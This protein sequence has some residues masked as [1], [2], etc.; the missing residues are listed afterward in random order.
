MKL[1]TLTTLAALLA[2]VALSGSAFAQAGAPSK[3]SGEVEANRDAPVSLPDAKPLPTPQVD[4]EKASRA[5]D[6]AAGADSY[7]TV[8][9]SRDGS[10]TE[11][12]ASDSLRAIVESSTPPAP[13]EK[14]GQLTVGAD[15]R[16]QI[17]DSSTYPFTA[18]G[19]LF[20]QNQSDGWATC[21]AA[22]IG[23]KTVITAAH[24]VYDHWNGGWMKQLMFVPGATDAE[25]APFGV[26]DWDSVHILQGYISNYDGE[27]YDSVM[28][29]DL[30]VIN[31][32]EPAGDT[33]G[34]LGFQIDNHGN[35]NAGIL[36]YPADKPEGTMWFA[37]C[38]IT[39]KNYGGLLP[40]ETG[41][42]F[43]HACDTYS[44]SSGSSIWELDDQD[45]PYVNGV[46]VAEDQERNYA[47]EINEANFNWLSQYYQ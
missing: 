46:N 11:T 33:L 37:K 47:T 45:L 8:T 10:V 20:G 18:I 31:L 25:T 43:W 39:D 12:E 42:N 22:L 7:G 35:W 17:T 23:P 27:T 5:L 26:F 6:G 28:P 40:V 15:D 44:G 14:A 9:L 24:C 13:G 34:W 36:G 38:A 30:A 1:S 3:G 16:L 41:N 4:P 21:S 19:W 32:I 2:G 29:W